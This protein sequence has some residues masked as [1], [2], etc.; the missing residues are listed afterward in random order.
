MLIVLSH[1]VRGVLMT[2]SRAFPILETLLSVR[3]I[4][5]ILLIALQVVS[6]SFFVGDV[7]SD[8]LAG[9][10]IAHTVYEGIATGSLLFGVALGCFELWHLTRRVQSSED[11]FQ[12]AT[13][14]FSDMIRRRF[15]EWNLSPAE[16]EVAL[17][18]LKGFEI[19]EIGKIRCT[20]TGTVRAQLS[21]IY[22]KAQVVSRSQ[23]VSL[24]VEVLIEAPPAG[25]GMP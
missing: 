23:F 2:V 19:P 20:A 25:Q 21:K 4:L 1:R 8:F 15:A 5:W 6:A 22:E 17:L 18:T 13:A 7:T 10:W 11:G 24:F 9:G 3:P 12:A 16:E 14:A